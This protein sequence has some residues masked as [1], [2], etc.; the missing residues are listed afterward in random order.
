M[1]AGDGGAA[2]GGGPTPLQRMCVEADAE[3]RA[4]QGGMLIIDAGI[5][6]GRRE[7]RYEGAFFDA[8]GR[9]LAAAAA[10]AAAARAGA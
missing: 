7:S 1:Q 9:R 2:E 3:A 5:V 10:H 6:D 4:T 8:L